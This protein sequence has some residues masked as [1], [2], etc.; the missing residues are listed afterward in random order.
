MA[1]GGRQEVEYCTTAC[2]RQLVKGERRGHC[3][4]GL[5]FKGLVT[6]RVNDYVIAQRSAVCWYLVLAK[7]TMIMYKCHVDVD[8]MNSK[9]VFYHHLIL[10][11]TLP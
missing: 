3:L 8:V 4:L 1:S 11:G 7:T 5:S 2:S 10:N 6:I 9:L